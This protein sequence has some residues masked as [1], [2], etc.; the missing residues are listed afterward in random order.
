MIK[1]RR[2]FADLL[3][4]YQVSW[5][6][7]SVLFLALLLVPG[8]RPQAQ[9]TRS[10]DTIMTGLAM[11]LA[12][13]FPVISGEVVKIEGERF[14]VSLGARDNLLQGTQLT[15]LREG[16]AL[17]QPTSGTS[18]GR[19]ETDIGVATVVHV[20]EHYAIATLTQRLAQQEVKAGDKVRITAGRIPLGLLPVVT[21][22]PQSAAALA[23]SLQRALEATNRFRVVAPDQ[24]AIWLLQRGEQPEGTIAPDLF[25]ELASAL[26]VSYLLIPRVRVLK[27]V[28]LLDLQLVSPSQPLTAVA[29]AAALLPETPDAMPLPAV[30]IP[31]LAQQTPT[32]EPAPGSPTAQAGQSPSAPATKPLSE[33]NA[34]G[35]LKTGPQPGVG[36]VTW[37][38]ADTLTEIAKFPILLQGIDGGDI[39]GNGTIEVGVLTPSEILLYRFTDEHLELIDRFTPAQPGTLLSLQLLRLQEHIGVVVNRQTGPNDMDSFVL[40]LQE[41]HLA[42]WQEHLNTILLAVDTDGDGVN[43]SVWG[44]P[45]DQREFFRQGTVQQYVIVDNRLRPQDSLPLPFAFR[46]TGAALGQLRR[47]EPRHLILID[48]NHRLRIYRNKEELWKSPL[49]VGG[50]NVSGET[51]EIIARDDMVSYVYFEP[52][53]AVID[54]NGDGLDDVLVAR[55]IGKTGFIPNVTSYSSGDVMLLREEKY[56]YTLSPISPQFN[57]IVSGIVTLPGHPLMILIAVTKQKSFPSHSGET[58]IY[59]SRLPVS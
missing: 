11:E 15:V 16:E 52:I 39:D 24:T 50:S 29:T 5:R 17:T 3:L 18:V 8:N 46:A 57:G 14:Y 27:D 19:V 36:A 33:P 25:P 43:E 21:Q 23:G 49:E 26:G 12:Q 44:Q 51:R 40:V 37:N 6:L 13:R 41:Q 48:A 59:L 9:T 30:P 45:F 47:N 55:N 7:W 20:A 54:V 35:A 1:E 56:G 34:S 53:P 22:A 10:L 2:L 58:W 32:V 31:G 28:P 42:L 38:L 4:E